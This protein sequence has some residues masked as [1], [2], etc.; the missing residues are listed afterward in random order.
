MFKTRPVRLLCKRWGAAAVA[1]VVLA[2]AASRTRASTPPLPVQADDTAIER[3]IQARIDA[4]A[5]LRAGK[6]D[7]DVDG[8]V[9]TL[10]GTVDSDG[11]KARAERLCRV[12]GVKVVNN[13]IAV[14]ARAAKAAEQSAARSTAIA[15]KLSSD[16]GQDLGKAL[17]NIGHR[18]GET[19]GEA[20]G[21]VSDS[22]ITTKVKT[23]MEND[24]A[25]VGRDVHVDTVSG[26]VTLRGQVP[27]AA[28]KAHAREAARGV[29]GVVRVVDD[30]RVGKR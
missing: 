3:K 9:A 2:G 22:V 26:V 23:Q 16:P 11:D 25:I 13:R 1:A 24:A 6:V 4:D 21:S 14:A 10:T 18:M 8:N 30:L 27:S 29:R 7:V 20:G 12:R 5:R 17:D 15:P 19:V 28:A